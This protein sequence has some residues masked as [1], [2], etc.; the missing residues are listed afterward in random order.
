[1]AGFSTAI[2]SEGFHRGTV[3]FLT[4]MTSSF[5]GWRRILSNDPGSELSFSVGSNDSGARLQMRASFMG[6]VSAEWRSE[7]GVVTDGSAWNHLV[8]TWDFS[9]GFNQRPR[10]YLNGS[11]TGLSLGA[12]V[13]GFFLTSPATYCLLC[14]NSSADP[15]MPTGTHDEFRIYR[16]PMSADWLRAEYQNYIGNFT[17]L[18][19]IEAL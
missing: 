5:N 13:N 1:V 3:S 11:Q 8:W 17:S 2:T 19:I 14:R 6:G 12:P 16:A 18:G 9:S 15:R 7:A 4:R 10:F